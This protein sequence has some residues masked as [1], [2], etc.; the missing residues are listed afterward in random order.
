MSARDELAAIIGTSDG[1]NPDDFTDHDW[2][3][4]RV[5]A[6]A[7]LAA[8]YSKARTI[9]TAEELDALN[10]G[11]V[12][13]S[14]DRIKMYDGAIWRVSGGMIVRVGKELND[15]VPY[16]YFIDPLPATVLYEP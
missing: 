15:V 11:A 5:N 12:L 16:R 13:M 9:T 14:G 8:G 7:V 6:D 1:F 10:E 2:D 3:D 4:Y